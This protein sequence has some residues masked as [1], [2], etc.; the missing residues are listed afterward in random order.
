MTYR[1][2]NVALFFRKIKIE[3]KKNGSVGIYP[4]GLHSS[5]GKEDKKIGSYF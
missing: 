1:R 3:K 5:G 4:S 2:K